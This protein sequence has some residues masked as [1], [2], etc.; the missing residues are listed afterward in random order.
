MNWHHFRTFVW[1]RWR[2]FVNQMARGG[3]ANTIILAILGSGV[4]MLSLVLLVGSFLIGFL[5]LP[6]APPLALLLVW[7]GVVV[8]FILS[9]CAGLMAELQRSEAFAL[10]KFM[11]LPVSLASAFLLN[12]FSSLV[13]LTMLLFAPVLVGLSL[14]LTFGKSPVLVVQ[15]PLAISFVFMATA[16]TYHFQGWL[17][18]LMVNKRRRRTI[19]VVV[20]LVFVL[21]FQVPN[22]INIYQPWKGLEGEQMQK[23]SAELTRA[24]NAKEITKD[25]FK[26]RQHE[27]LRD[28]VARTRKFWRD[29]EEWAWIANV[30]L[31]P[32][33]VAIG[34][35]SAAEGNPLPG[36]LAM[37]GFAALGAASLWRA[38]RTTLRIY[39]GQFTAGGRT[40][41]PVAAPNARA[42]ALPGTRDVGLVGWTLPWI[43]DEAAAIALAGFQSLV[44]APE[45]KM[46][47]LSPIIMLVIF[48]G[49]LL[50][51]GVSE[52]PD[53]VRPL[54]S[55]GAIA[56]ML[57][58]MG[59][60]AGNQFGYD[61]GGFK[62]FVLSPAPRREILLGKNLALAPLVF[63]LATPLIILAQVF[64]PTSIDLMVAIPFQFVTMFL[65]YCM[66]ANLLSMFAPMPIAS[67]S[68]KPKSPRMI[69]FLL[70][71]LFV[72]TLPMAQGPTLL[73]LGIE[74]A[75]A[76]LDSTYGIPICLLLT[77]L[78]CAIVVF[79]YRLVIT[80][81]GWLLQSRELRI[82]EVVAAKAE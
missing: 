64:L 7:D 17:A 56:M 5:A 15:L 32:G 26:K 31:P 52:A 63:G 47:L 40:P 20:T 36:L 78:E 11:H 39:S 2:L 41:T 30:A 21:I 12:Y 79:L 62:N 10:D 48:G 75:L 67:G 70:T 59:Q 66:L 1:L 65:I 9:W 81:Q 4:V 27:I 51:G 69:P 57:F 28:S 44:R 76:A 33:W 49:L 38:Y 19:I 35:S 55:F 3:I 29:A 68:M 77:V 45:V 53:M 24:L 71:M 37:F 13:S 14:G 22:L 74:A 43:S 73:P 82:L 34:A 6:K 72:F 60:L 42:P 58:T 16:L 61:R 80:W 18:S 46:L 54:I 25:E 8:V 50:R 23:E